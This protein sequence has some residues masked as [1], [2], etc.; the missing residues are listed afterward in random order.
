MTTILGI[1]LGTSKVACVLYDPSARKPLALSSV[2]HDSALEAGSNRSEQE[3]AGIFNAVKRCLEKLPLE[4]RARVLAVGVTGQMHG[5]V[6]WNGEEGLLSPLVTWQDNRCTVSGFLDNLRQQTGD[7]TIR[8]GYGCATLAWFAREDK[9]GGGYSNAATI[10]DFLVSKMC[11]LERPV[12]DPTDAASWGFFDVRSGCW[13]MDL[14]RAAGIDANMLPEIVPSGTVAGRLIDSYARDWGLPSGI[15]VVAAI[16]DNQASLLATLNDPAHEAALT[17]G[18]GGQLS[19]VIDDIDDMAVSPAVEVRPYVNK[20]WIA[21]CASLCGGSA[22]QW[23][24]RSIEEWLRELRVDAPDEAS[25]YKLVDEFA[26]ANTNPTLSVA[27]SFLGERHAPDIR[28]SIT[29]LTPDN[30]RLREVSPALIRSVPENLRLMMPARLL[31]GRQTI[32]GSGN[33]LRR[34][35]SLRFYTERVFNVPLIITDVEEEA[36]CGAALLASQAACTFTIHG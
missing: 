18:T 29:G 9:D 36:A 15:P 19:V 6:R 14:I 26:L 16:G 4:D 35:R 23:L 22:I 25:L 7:Q 3:V 20:A 33:A 1:D 12:M 30:F 27:S 21:V 28:G 13:R 31:Q 11:G 2:P 32:V 34:L 17:L 8:S 5:V 10:H 24:V